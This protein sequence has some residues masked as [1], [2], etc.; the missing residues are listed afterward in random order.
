MKTI[1]VSFVYHIHSSYTMQFMHELKH[2]LIKIIG[3][4]LK[5]SKYIYK[6]TPIH[7]HA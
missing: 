5:W 1:D 7:I 4:T 2:K 6:F 3:K